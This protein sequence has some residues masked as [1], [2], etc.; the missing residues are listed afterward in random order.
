MKF[1]QALNYAIDLQ[2]VVDL[3]FMGSTVPGTT[4]ITPNYYQ[5]PDWHWEPPADVKYWFDPEKAKRPLDA[6]GLH[7]TRTATGGGSTR[8]SP[9]SCA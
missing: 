4:I 3:V 6:A 7:R 1:R 8:A 2:K 9:S 5:D